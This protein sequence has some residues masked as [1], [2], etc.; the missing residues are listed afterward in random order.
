MRQRQKIVAGNWKMNNDLAQ[1]SD[2]LN[3]IKDQLTST[4]EV[5]L[6]VAPSFTNLYYA[7]EALRDLPIDVAAQNLNEHK[8]GAYTG[9]VSATMLTSI[10]VKTVIIG[11][12][13]RRALFNETDE[14]LAKKVSAALEQDMEVIF[15][16]GEEL[17]QRKDQQHFEV[18][19]DQLKKALFHISAAALEKVVIAYEPVWA[20][21][22]GETA[23]PEQAQEMHAYIRKVISEQFGEEIAGK[24]SILYGGSVKPANAAEIFEKPDVDGG[25]IGGASLK[26]EDFLAIAK[27]F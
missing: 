8:S 1:T 13:E 10:G 16:C 15:C 5:R 4:P 2:L 26:A 18:V 6:I 3:D 20:I 14:L 24:M 23:S 12:S 22:T 7:F 11:H 25:L 21:G 19:R 9:E 27:S 17:Q